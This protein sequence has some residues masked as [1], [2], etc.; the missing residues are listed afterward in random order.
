[1]EGDYSLVGMRSGRKFRMGDK[2]QDQVLSANLE[3]RQLD[4]GWVLAPSMKTTI[5]Q[6]ISKSR[7]IKNQKE[8]K[9]DANLRTTIAAIH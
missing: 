5:L 6:K 7:K 8:K 9:I 1:V 4:Y 3:K 2:V